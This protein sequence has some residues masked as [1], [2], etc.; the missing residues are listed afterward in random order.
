MKKLPEEEV[1]KPKKDKKI[2]A[3]DSSK[4][5]KS[6]K[7]VSP[8][9]DADVTLVSFQNVT[10]EYDGGFKCLEDVSFDISKGEFVFLVG[11]SG[12]GKSSLVK[13]LIREQLP[14]SGS[15]IFDDVDI[16]SIPQKE[17]HTLRRRV[18]VVF[19]D[20]KVLPSKNVFGNVAI[21][22][23]V[24]D[25]PKDRICDVVENVLT[26]VGLSDKAN[27]FPAELSGG[28]LQRVSIAR[29]LAH[30][31]DL[32]VADEPTGNIDPV[33]SQKVIDIFEKVNKMGVAVLMATHDDRVVDKL[34][35]RVVRLENGKVSSDVKGGKYAQSTK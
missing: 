9:T 7:P 21:A 32:L 35:K 18:G 15:I 25:T 12:A 17:I 31:P 26:L 23:E 34:K 8:S 3:A 5:A 33:A 28:E 2:K 10:K 19:Q 6:P 13:L 27:S 11:R 1:E 22:L 4:P 20:F 24:V 14:S 29:A 16:A 30:E